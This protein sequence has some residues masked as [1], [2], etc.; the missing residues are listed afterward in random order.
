MYILYV[1]YIFSNMKYIDCTQRSK[2]LLRNHRRLRNSSPSTPGHHPR[3]QAK[4]LA[5]AKAVAQAKMI[6]QLELPQ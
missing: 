1:L 4:T 5:Q 3:A 2:G 6:A